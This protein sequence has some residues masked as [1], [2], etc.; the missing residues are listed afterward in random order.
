MRE[1]LK[2]IIFEEI[3]NENPNFHETYVS[4]HLRNSEL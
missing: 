3:M 2:R 1:K 4:K